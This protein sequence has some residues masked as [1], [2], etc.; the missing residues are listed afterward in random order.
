[1]MYRKIAQINPSVQNVTAACG[2][3]V[4]R[5]TEYAIADALWL[6]GKLSR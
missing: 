1:M 4:A 6:D 2:Y 5:I 3:A